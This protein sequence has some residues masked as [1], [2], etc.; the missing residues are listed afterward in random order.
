MKADS[1]ANRFA[2]FVWKCLSACESGSVG[3][4]ACRQFGVLNAALDDAVALASTNDRFSHLLGWTCAA[5]N[6]GMDSMMYRY[7][8]HGIHSLFLAA[9]AEWKK[10]F[11]VI[12]E[13]GCGAW[14]VSADLRVF[15]IW[16]CK[17]LQKML[18]SYKR[19]MKDQF[20]GVTLSFNFIRKP[21]T[22]K[23]GTA[24]GIAPSM[25]SSTPVPSTAAVPVTAAAS[26]AKAVNKSKNNE[27]LSDELPPPKD[28]FALAPNDTKKTVKITVVR[29]T[30]DHPLGLCIVWAGNALKVKLI[31]A[32]SLFLG[33]QLTAGMLL[34]TIN[35]EAYATFTE[36]ME[37]VKKAVGKMVVVTS[38]PRLAAAM[39]DNLPT[40]SNA[41]K[42][43]SPPEAT[44]N[45]LIAKV[46]KTVVG[47]PSPSDVKKLATSPAIKEEDIA[48][49]DEGL[50]GC[51]LPSIPV[52]KEEDI[53]TD[54]EAGSFSQ[55][56]K[57]M[58]PDAPERNKSAFHHVKA[59]NPDAEF[60]E[61]AHIFSRHFKGLSKEERS[62]WDE[63][64]AQDKVRYEREMERYCAAKRKAP[65]E[66]KSDPSIANVAKKV[67]GDE[68]TSMNPHATYFFKLEAVARHD[69]PETCHM[70]IRGISTGSNDSD[71]EEE[72]EED[73]D[74]DTSKYT[75]E[76]MSTLR[77]VLINKTR[78]YRLD[79]MRRFLLGDQAGCGFLMF[80]TSY[81]N[82]VMWGFDQF[83]SRMYPTAKTPANKFNLLFAYTYNLGQHD[84]WMYDNEGV[85]GGM[86]KSLAGMWKKL[87]K[88]DDEI[89]NIDS[90]YTR[91]G[92][93][94]FLRNFK[95]KIEAVDM[96]PYPAF[97][98]NFQ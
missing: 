45:F 44:S 16:N 95:E 57:K 17:A 4:D 73:D 71:E 86:V 23:V 84:V 90:E 31:N 76:Q 72:E 85:M 61:I 11:K 34:E 52:V 19:E 7:C 96:G 15:A 3:G 6:H 40:S 43:K 26:T 32:P 13:G 92:V 56:T 51:K 35:G 67:V 60:G 1:D 82:E 37:L 78:H 41:A 36:G 28:L 54:E 81:S 29:P 21:R 93:E 24:I 25:S 42:R 74:E 38:F 70:L 10:V 18:R 55:M 53:E 5:F 48:M 88:N 64:A 98:F 94:E 47:D 66:A 59:A 27:K 58:S 63:T 62:H 87:L 77:V 14:E 49:D 20:K 75:A 65:N 89:L 50:E 33:T 97:K 46:A 69:G 12:P 80:N 2:M 39:P 8:P 68:E 9:A 79:K 22:K 83:K 91:P 30:V